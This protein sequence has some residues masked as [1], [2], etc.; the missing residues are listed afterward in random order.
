M[1]KKIS[2]VSSPPVIHLLDLLKHADIAMDFNYYVNDNE[3]KLFFKNLFDNMPC[4]G[5]V[6]EFQTQRY[7]YVNPKAVEDLT[8]YSV[9]TIIKKGMPFFVSRLHPD[10]ITGTINDSL[11]ALLPSLHK[12]AIEEVK[13]CKISYSYR[14]KRKDNT[15]MQFLLEYIILEMDEE[16]LPLILLTSLM[17][18]TAIDKKDN[19]IIYMFSHYEK[20]NINTNSLRPNVLKKTTERE[21]EVIRL[22]SNGTNTKEIAEKLGLSQFTIR[23]HKRNIFKKTNTRN[24]AELTG[25]AFANGIING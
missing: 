11:S 8:G 9:K 17:D 5:I 2:K 23:A 13:Q 10:D 19:A 7:L 6:A 25:Y 21:N 3:I 22:I 12:N 15:W 16:G 20:Q 14:F 18:S 24:I 1:A 4:A